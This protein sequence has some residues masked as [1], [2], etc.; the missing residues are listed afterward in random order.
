MTIREITG[1]LDASHLKVG[2]V[3]GR[4]N[5]ALTKQLLESALT[6][7]RENGAVDEN[8][9]VVWVPGADDIP[10]AMSHLAEANPYDTYLALGCVIQGETLHAEVIASHVSLSLA[11]LAKTIK[12]PVING[13]VTAGN[14]DQAVERCGIKARNRGKHATEAAIEMANLYREAL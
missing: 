10:L 8:M 11:D 2:I 7:L 4:F 9:V 6:V 5:E 13:V 1:S 3:V 12:R 14:Y